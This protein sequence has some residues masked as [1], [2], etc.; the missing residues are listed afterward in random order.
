MMTATAVAMIR[1]RRAPQEANDAPLPVG[2]VLLHG[3][4]VGLTTGIIGAGAASS[5][6]P[7]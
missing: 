3:G 7:P 6:C 4:A 5:S 1:G 2:R